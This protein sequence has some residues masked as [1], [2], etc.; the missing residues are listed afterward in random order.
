LNLLEK[1]W[2]RERNEEGEDGRG[3]DDNRRLSEWANHM[4]DPH[5]IHLNPPNFFYFL[6]LL[7]SYKL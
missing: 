2:V 3:E 7:L 5:K 6:V 1:R 4:F